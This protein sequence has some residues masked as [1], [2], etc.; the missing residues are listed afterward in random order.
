M[1]EIQ[2]PT[3]RISAPTKGPIQANISAD[4]AFGFFACTQAWVAGSS[5]WVLPKITVID[6]GSAIEKPMKEPKVTT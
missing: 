1:S 5:T 2:P 4:G 6:S 3:G